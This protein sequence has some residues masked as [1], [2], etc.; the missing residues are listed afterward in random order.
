MEQLSLKRQ[1]KGEASTGFDE[2]QAASLGRF[3]SMDTQDIPSYTQG[4]LTFVDT[5][6]DYGADTQGVDYGYTFTPLSQTQTQT[7]SQLT[8]NDPSVKG[9]L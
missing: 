7:Q 9:M 4:P 6:V 3:L 8:Q 1:M 5:D 2:S